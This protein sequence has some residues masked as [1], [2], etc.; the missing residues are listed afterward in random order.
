MRAAAMASS[1]VIG[2]S[3]SNSRSQTASRSAACGPR[4]RNRLEYTS[5]KLTKFMIAGVLLLLSSDSISVAEGS[6]PP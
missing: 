2:S 4:S 5:L 3:T 6:C 1:G